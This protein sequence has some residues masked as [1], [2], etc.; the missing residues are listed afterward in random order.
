MNLEE[1]IYKTV[2]NAMMSVMLTKFDLFK[3]DSRY[4][5]RLTQEQ[6][7][8]W[9]GIGQEKFDYYIR[10][11]MPVVRKVDG[12]IDFV[13]RDAVKDWFRYQWAEIGLK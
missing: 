1:T 4:G 5:P 8:K 13:P 9:L 12:N 10:Q 3:T 2:E 7:K 11:G 6:A